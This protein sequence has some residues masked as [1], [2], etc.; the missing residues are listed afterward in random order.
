MILLPEGLSHQNVVG[1]S[2]GFQPPS[3]KDQMTMSFFR[4]RG[5]PE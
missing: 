4:P 2:K 3:V 5:L 1:L